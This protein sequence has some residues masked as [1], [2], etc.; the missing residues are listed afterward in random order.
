MRVKLCLLGRTAEAGS[1]SCPCTRHACMH[2]HTHTHTQLWPWDPSSKGTGGG[3]WRWVTM[4]AT[5]GRIQFCTKPKAHLQTL[6]LWYFPWSQSFWISPPACHGCSLKDVWTWKT[7]LAVKSQKT[8]WDRWLSYNEHQRG[9]LLCTQAICICTVDVKCKMLSAHQHMAFGL[10]QSCCGAAVTSK[11]PV[12]TSHVTTLFC[13]N[14][15]HVLLNMLT[16]A[17][18]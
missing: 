13:L 3:F 18:L 4:K 9:K 8:S 17:Q 12:N 6:P 16:N 11:L 10:T 2:T 5:S 7:I 14:S 15:Q 1:E